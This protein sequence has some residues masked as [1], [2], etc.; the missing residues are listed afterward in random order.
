MQLGQ[1]S[2]GCGDGGGGVAVAANAGFI[3]EMLVVLG[4]WGGGGNIISLAL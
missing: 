4:N 2:G 3:E 1:V